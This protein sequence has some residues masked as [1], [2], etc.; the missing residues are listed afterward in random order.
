MAKR[1]LKWNVAV[2]D[3]PQVIGAGKVLHVACQFSP[4]SVQVWTEESALTEGAQRTVQVY[5]TGQPIPFDAV[6]LG[7]T[8]T[9]N[10]A[11]VW[12]LYDVTF[13]VSAS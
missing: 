7:S 8:V 10:G 6:Y 11:L 3:T 12:H 5:G 9:G 1:V 4:E 2:D 13:E